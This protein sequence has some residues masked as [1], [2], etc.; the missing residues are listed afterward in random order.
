MNHNSIM[1]PAAHLGFQVGADYK[2]AD[3]RQITEYF[4]HL[5]ERSD[6]ILVEEIGKSTEGR[7]M[8]LATISASPNLEKLDYYRN[9]QAQLADP[10]GLTRERAQQL[11][12]E[13]KTICLITCSVHASEVGAAQMSMELAYDMLTKDDSVTQEILENVIFLFV[14]SLNPDGLDMVKEWYDSSLGTSYEGMMMPKLYQKYA[15]HDNNRDWFMATLVE[16]RLAIEKIHNVWHPHIVHDQH[17]QSSEG[18]R[19][20]LPPFI[21]PYD[22]NV[23]PIL[24]GMVNWLGMSMASEMNGR[25]FTGI[26]TNLTYDAFSPS[27]AYQHYHG[28]VRILSEAASVRTASP[29]HIDE[30]R[31]VR[32]F[33]PQEATWNHPQPWQGGDWRLRDIVDYDK[34]CAWACLRHAARYRDSWVEN[35][36]RIHKKA[37]SHEEAPY[38]FIIPLDQSDPAT[39]AEMLDV[40]M[41]GGVEVH[42][43]TAAFVADGVEYPEGSLIIFMAQPYGRYAKTLLEAQP[44]PDL[45]LYPGGPPRRPYDITAHSLPL[46]MGV[47]VVTVG[48]PLD[49][50]GERLQEVPL[51][52]A[53]QHEFEVESVGGKALLLTADSNMA[54]RLAYKALRQG[55][56][57]SRIA[58]ETA[59][60]AVGSFLLEGEAETLAQISAQAAPY[61]LRQ[62]MVDPADMETKSHTHLPRI[63]LY[64]GHVPNA[65]EGWTRYIFDNY[66]IP[67]VSVDDGQLRRGHVLADLDCLILPSIQARAMTEGLPGDVYPPEI[68]G[69]LGR[70]GAEQIRKFVDRGGTLIAFDAAT[71]WAIDELWLPV[72][73]T[74]KGLP[75]EEFYVPG[76]FLRVLMQPDHPLTYGLPRETNVVFLHSPAFEVGPGAV[77]VGTYPLQNPMVAGWILGDQHLQGRSALVEVP[78]GKGRVTLIG[79]R[80]QFRA[81]ARATYKVLFNAILQSV[82]D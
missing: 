80:S 16:N 64:K 11:V 46:Q 77:S 4:Y 5:A 28:G 60:F 52:V 36:Y 33:D 26:A 12:A 66:E 21:D 48:H 79:F 82:L 73:N 55:V 29:V 50:A 6:R 34:A 27:R 14:P 20:V 70:Q 40:L 25:G 54:Y 32:G 3:W 15:G 30:L 10:R 53:Y 9:I 63:G 17:Q 1:P 51:A 56:K 59:G 39:A 24:R 7:P 61:A 37:V 75:Q 13:G 43:A 41:L 72:K 74:L 18:P 78:L 42:R 44:Y 23:D 38:A 67:Y 19:F 2:L 65:D 68:S 57:L 49:C 8:L 69:G 58:A 62:K 47:R 76:S 22:E 71:E 45:R 31:E 35:F 81:Q